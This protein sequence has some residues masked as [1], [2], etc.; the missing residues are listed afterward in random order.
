LPAQ[1]LTA[2]FCREVTAVAGKPIEYQDTQTA[3]LILRVSSAGTKSWSLR[4][5]AA[6]KRLRIPLGD[7]PA[8]QLKDARA[9]VRAILAST[10]KAAPA[11]AKSDP[12][13]GPTKQGMEGLNT[14]S[15]I[16]HERKEAWHALSATIHRTGLSSSSQAE[17]GEAWPDNN[18]P[19]VEAR[20]F[21]AVEETRNSGRQDALRKV[22]GFLRGAGRPRGSGRPEQ[23]DML[24]EAFAFFVTGMPRKQIPHA[25][26][27]PGKWTNLRKAIKEQK[28]E[29]DRRFADELKKTYADKAPR[30][31]EASRTAVA[32]R[33]E[34]FFNSLAGSPAMEDA[35]LH[36]QKVLGC[37]R[38][39]ARQEL[40]EKF[41]R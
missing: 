25:V 17:R 8:V 1:Y 15:D 14:L 29:I 30:R 38:E 6:G 10:K 19:E 5:R 23:L 20:L 24:V 28:P 16:M 31:R 36:V 32:A 39:T 3:G 35:I 22:A 27:Y 26:G 13:P 40:R 34:Q 33:K 11:R 18:W 12:T 41:T 2:K 37:D 4:R 21:D 9:K 7:Y